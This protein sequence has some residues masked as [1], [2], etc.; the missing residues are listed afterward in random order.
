MGGSGACMAALG[1]SSPAGDQGGDQPPE[2]GG[3]PRAARHMCHV[4][5]SARPPATAALPALL[6]H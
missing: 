4:T 5:R 3:S 2:G 1:L 6:V